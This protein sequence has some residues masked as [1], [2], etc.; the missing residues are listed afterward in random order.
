MSR[1]DRR[2]PCGRDIAAG[3]TTRIWL[4]RLSDSTITKVP[5]TNSNDF[6]PMWAGDRVY[7]LSDRNGPV[8]LFYYDVK[9]QG[10]PRGDSES[11][12]GF[13]VG[14]A[15]P[16]CDRLRTVRRDLICTT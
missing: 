7:F 12:A 13:E 8:T 9:T 10:R 15:R 3:R 2:S 14:L 6:N 11:R 4:A 1:S 16:G 5:R